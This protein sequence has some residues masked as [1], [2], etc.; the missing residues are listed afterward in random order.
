MP[1]WIQWRRYGNGSN[2]AQTISSRYLQEATSNK[3]MTIQNSKED[4]IQC[5]CPWYS[6][7]DEYQLHL[8]CWRSNNLSLALSLWII[9][10]VGYQSSDDSTIMKLKMS[11]MICLCPQGTVDIRTHKF[12]GKVE[13]RTPLRC[14]VDLCDGLRTTQSGFVWEIPWY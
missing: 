2:E 9:W 12:L 14:Y 11:L 4:K 8:Q 6:I 1:F 7:E 5:L 3:C 10:R 13:R